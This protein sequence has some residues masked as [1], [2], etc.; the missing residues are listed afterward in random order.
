MSQNILTNIDRQNSIFLSKNTPKKGRNSERNY[1]EEVILGAGISLEPNLIIVSKE[2]ALV[3]RDITKILESHIAFPTNLQEFITGFKKACTDDDYFKR[4]LSFT[5]LRKEDSSFTVQQDSLI[6]I[7]LNVTCIQPQMIAI[8]LKHI[9]N[10][11]IEENSDASFLRLLLNSLR[12]LSHIDDSKMLTTKLV[13]VLEVATYAA[14]L[15]II[16]SIPEIIPDIEYEETAQQLSKL[17][18]QKPDLIGA[19][20]DCLNSLNLN[21][22][23]RS[24]IQQQVLAQFDATSSSKMFP[25]LFEFIISECTSK[26]LENILLQ[27]R[28]VLDSILGDA[29]SSNEKESTKVLICNQLR[30]LTTSRKPLFEG[31]L[32]LISSIRLNTDVKPVD[33]LILF[34]LHSIGK[35]RCASIELLIRKRIKLGLFKITQLEALFKSYFT[36]QILKDY[37]N[38]IVGI[39]IRLLRFYN[40]VPLTEF[41]QIIFKLLFSHDLTNKL[42]QQEIVYNLTLLVG[43]SD[44]K[45]VTVVL[46]TL[47]VLAEDHIKLQQHTVQ[48]M[49]LLEKLNKINMNNVKLVFELLCLLTCGEKSDDSLSGLNDEIHM[50]I[51]K[52]LSSS[53]KINKHR[54]IIAAIVMIKHIVCT[55]NDSKEHINLDETILTDD[56]PRGGPQEGAALLEL[57]NTCTLGSPDCLGLLYDELAH[58]IITIKNI[59]QIFMIWLY[60]MFTN[61]FQQIFVV[62]VVPKPINDIVLVMQFSLNSTD[63]VDAPIAMN[64]AELTLKSQYY[65]RS[66]ILTLS[67]LFR[68][69]QLIHYKHHDGD[70]SSIDALLGCAVIL[71]NLDDINIYDNEQLKEVSNCLF[72]CINWFRELINAFVTQNNRKL[73]MKVLNRISDAIKLQ[74]ILEECLENVPNHKLPLSYFDTLEFCYTTKQK[75]SNSTVKVLNVKKK[76]KVSDTETVANIDETIPCTSSKTKVA[77][78][79]KNDL[80]IKRELHFRDMDTDV[81][82]LLR[83]PLKIDSD[84]NITHTQ[85][86]QTEP[87]TLSIHQFIFL[88]SDLVH[89]LNVLTKGK[90]LEL[91]HISVVKIDDLITDC[92][93]LLP[94]L[95]KHQFAITTSLNQLLE[96]ADG[97]LDS[98]QLYRTSAKQLKTSFGLIIECYSLIFGWSGFQQSKNLLLLKEHLKVLRDEQQSQLISAK[99][100]ILDFCNKLLESANYCL[101]LSSAVSLINT[102]EALY[103]ANPNSDLKKLISITSEKL[104]SKKWYNDKKMIETG[105]DAFLNL[106]KL[107]AAYLSNTVPKT[108]CGLIGTLQEQAPNLKIKEDSLPM[109]IS[110]DKGNFHI[111]YRC[112]CSALLEVVRNNISSLTNTEHLVLWKSVTLS[113]QGLVTVV[114]A[115]ETKINLISYVKN[116]IGILKV[117]LSSGIPILE[118]ML[119]S[120]TTEVLEIFKTMQVSTRF[121][122][123]ICCDS[124]FRKDISLV[125]YV[126]QF[127]QV[128]ESL[129]Y[130]VKAALVA[131]GC[132]DAFWMGTLKNKNIRGEEIL[133]Q[134]TVQADDISEAM[135][136]E[137]FPI[138]DSDEVIEDDDTSA[139]DIV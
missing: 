88:M 131:N 29:S 33:I 136:S 75:S 38:A 63:E 129:V 124:K 102:M 116:S 76:Q 108:L 40:E 16:N 128:L 13:D 89:K 53:K 11:A 112:L 39:G 51:R 101:L 111:F 104:L 115:H 119:P 7:F 4:A 80:N 67:P 107:V 126:P 82:I 110:I 79:K 106:S 99:A 121:L 50:T 20:V 109:L 69:L 43:M 66:S 118:I 139:S 98:E 105:K 18:D 59:H 28:N 5:E 14:Q 58:M 74:E 3:V 21:A 122:H 61:D 45:G 30:A 93:K 81:I 133:T 2:Q 60:H 123:H 8:V 120:K 1:F 35:S 52:Q 91:S 138:D 6:R 77:T 55:S 92:L 96:T 71:P 37:F 36:P 113:L 100:L 85:L 46:K 125:A 56:L 73:R 84:L 49:G 47:L 94:S 78:K 87:I 127:R 114:K 26:D 65:E 130:R 70:L 62:E 27:A 44:K 25:I 24:E 83:Y 31:W 103:L 34:M 86:S 42:H 117:F 17:L 134:S 10:C 9:T 19:I 97:C 54:G 95:K 48:L 32:T 41:S 132:S 15:D 64:I 90:D 23:V 68:L 12:Y 72:H 57:T 137:E 135:E 22:N